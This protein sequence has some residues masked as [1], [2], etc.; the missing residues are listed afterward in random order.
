M[1]KIIFLLTCFFIT[2][3]FAFDLSFS[4][5]KN[6][7]PR[8]F[9]CPIDIK[10]GKGVH[11]KGDALLITT[12]PSTS[13]DHSSQIYGGL[14][15][16]MDAAKKLK[17]PSVVLVD[18]ISPGSSYFFPS[19]QS[20]QYIS[21]NGGEFDFTFD[22][23]HVITT[24][25]LTRLC[26]RQSI[27]HILNE[28]SRKKET[29]DL[30]LVMILDAS[31]DGLAFFRQSM[32]ESPA[33]EKMTSASFGLMA[34]SY[35]SPAYDKI[36]EYVSIA[37]DWVF[38][39]ERVFRLLDRTM[40]QGTSFKWLKQY[41]LDTIQMPLIVATPEKL[42]FPPRHTVKLHYFY[43]QRQSSESSST[44]VGIIDDGGATV[45]QWETLVD[46]GP[47]APTLTITVM[48]SADLLGSGYW[49]LK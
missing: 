9:S 33:M 2:P 8:E 46:R 23:R 40:G 25:G 13:F 34:V 18:P 14:S 26:Q 21:S 12:H 27:N 43:R 5:N 22:A 28:W 20:N 45:D 32:R 10:N 11:F 47:S 4:L 36:N 7:D 1:R 30:S 19:C 37:G 16:V 6:K 3:A 38:S 29:R 24:G 15:S 31:F 41:F 44:S 35:D 39:L 48:H 42:N 17:I 49:Q